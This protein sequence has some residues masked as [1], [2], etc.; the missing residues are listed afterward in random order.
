M[1][2][3]KTLTVIA[4]TDGKKAWEAK[5][6]G[7]A[8]HLGDGNL[9]WVDITG[10][11]ITKAE[12]DAI[13][14]AAVFTWDWEKVEIDTPLEESVEES[15]VKTAPLKTDDQKDAIEILLGDEIWKK[16]IAAKR[17]GNGPAVFAYLNIYVAL[18]THGEKAAY[19]I[20]KSTGI[21]K[22]NADV[23]NAKTIWKAHSTAK[24]AGRSIEAQTHLEAY[25]A[26]VVS[27]EKE[28]RKTYKR[29]LKMPNLVS[30]KP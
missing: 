29:A 20:Y 12:W 27:G 4:V 5:E 14:D 11:K 17:E 19:K 15:T 13:A 30:R 2:N 16:L 24:K 10:T 1:I 18:V 9:V 23:L 21:G 22:P 28:A 7:A 6:R 8:T 3:S 25:G 26:V